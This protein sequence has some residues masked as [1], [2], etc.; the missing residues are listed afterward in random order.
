MSISKPLDQHWSWAHK[1]Q[2]ENMGVIMFFFLVRE[3]IVC[4][5]VMIVSET[6]ILFFR[7]D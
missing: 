6:G 2:K 1:G 3:D 7:F 4:W 5:V